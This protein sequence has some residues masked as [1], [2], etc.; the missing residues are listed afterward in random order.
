MLLTRC[1]PIPQVKVYYQKTVSGIRHLY[2][3][4]F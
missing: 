3:S 4:P 2:T 1:D